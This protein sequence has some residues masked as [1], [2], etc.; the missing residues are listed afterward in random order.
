MFE[1]NKEEIKKKCIE[2]FILQKNI[3]E[4]CNKL[5]QLVKEKKWETVDRQD[6]KNKTSM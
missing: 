4:S 3:F 6:K 1:P 5:K 2:I